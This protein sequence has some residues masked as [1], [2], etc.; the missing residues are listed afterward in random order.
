MS[1]YNELQRL[2][3]TSRTIY[4]RDGP[5]TKKE[6]KDWKTKIAENW[7]SGLTVGLVNL[8]LCISLAIA[9]SM[10]P[11]SGLISGIF[12]GLSSGFWGGSHYNI[13]GPT[14]A[15]SG[16]IAI[17]VARYGYGNI[18]L[19]ALVC[20][21]AI[22]LVRYFKLENYIDLFPTAVNEGFTIGVAGIIFLGQINSALGI[23]PLPKL[24]GEEE[25]TTVHVL[26]KNLININL[27]RYQVF[28]LYLTCFLGLYFAIK[29]FPTVPWM[30]FSAIIGIFIG[31]YYPET[32]PT[33]ESRYKIHFTL[34]ITPQ[35][36]PF[37]LVDPRFYSDCLP[38]VFVVVLETLISAKIADTM[39]RTKDKFNK[40][41]E[42]LALSISNLLSGLFGGLPVT[43]ALA[44]TSLNIRSGANHKWSSLINSIFLLLLG[45]LFFGFFKYVPLGIV[46]AQVCIVAV[47]MINMEE[48]LILYEKENRNFYV[49][50]FIGIVCICKDP[51]SGIV[52]GMLVY[53]LFFS[54]KMT[55]SWCD[56]FFA[57]IGQEIEEQKMICGVIADV[58]REI[59]NYVVYRFVGIVNYMNIEKH[60]KNISSVVRKNE[61]KTLVLSFLYV[62][63]VDNEALHSISALIEELKKENFKDSDALGSKLK[64]SFTKSKYHMI[65]D[66]EFFEKLK[67]YN[68]F[69]YAET[70]LK[71]ELPDNQ[72]EMK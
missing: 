68:I 13:V 42:L 70:D 11:E 38:I 1:K 62:H 18:S 50:I 56:I 63:F 4:L 27:F 9:S 53:L 5:I 12:A 3:T 29:K 47:R 46:A 16:F 60:Y 14:G 69:Y 33:I 34:F 51:T 59:G 17:C 35:I 57:D 72:E 28:L 15:L 10:S 66:S 71:N 2:G 44:R 48:L 25:Q 21:F 6:K 32:F 49:S 64:I 67:Q 22:L 24:P 41:K 20:S 55:D 40:K 30:I 7:Q 58:P 45:S 61:N 37:L 52:F 31:M 8:P 19:F 26:I 65:N 23:G 54:E 43:A 36:N 39:V